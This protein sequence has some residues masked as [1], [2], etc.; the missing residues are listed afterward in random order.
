MLARS[1]AVVI[2]LLVSVAPRAFQAQRAG[3]QSGADL[4]ARPPAPAVSRPALIVSIA[5]VGV[6]PLLQNE[7]V[8][9]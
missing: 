1:A 3:S 8:P 2:G 5:G 7:S 4:P 9:Q 6:M